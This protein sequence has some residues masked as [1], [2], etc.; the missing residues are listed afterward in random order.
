M[1]GKKEVKLECE[2]SKRLIELLKATFNEPRISEVLGCNRLLCI[3]DSTGTI[4]VYCLKHSMSNLIKLVL[5]SNLPAI[6]KPQG[7][8]GILLGTFT[9]GKV[10][11]SLHLAYTLATRVSEKSFMPKRGVIVVNWRGE[12]AF[13]FSKPVSSQDYRVLGASKTNIYLVLSAQGDPL[14]WGTINSHRKLVP[15]IDSGWFLRAGG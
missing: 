12:K 15:L 8:A 10:Q 1:L 6:L 13:T 11:L 3:A 9:K 14:G 4:S 2:E 7:H 5:E